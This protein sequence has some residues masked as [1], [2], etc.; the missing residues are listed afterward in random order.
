M[1]YLISYDITNDRLRTQIAKVLKR[2]GCHRLQKSVFIA[3]NYDAK[4]LGKTKQQL[5]KWIPEPL[6]AD[7]SII[8][9]PIEADNI[10]QILWAG[11]TNVLKKILEVKL[12]RFL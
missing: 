2:Q 6:Q 4:K 3:P 5:E 8:V 9:V 7:E 10:S 11:D 12:F 1:T